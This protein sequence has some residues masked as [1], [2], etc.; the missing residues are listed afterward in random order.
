MHKHLCV[1]TILWAE[2]T[3]Q[4]LLQATGYFSVF[5]VFFLFLL[6]TF[7]QI[8]FEWEL[9][10]CWQVSELSSEMYMA[11]FPLNFLQLRLDHCF[12]QSKLQT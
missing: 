12:D 9:E 10:A 7:V 2:K 6:C 11:T 3:S 8:L 4:I 5:A 1:Q